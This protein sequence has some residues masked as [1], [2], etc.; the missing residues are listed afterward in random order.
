MEHRIKLTAQSYPGD[1]GDDWRQFQLTRPPAPR[2]TVPG[3]VDPNQEIIR[4]DNVAVPASLPI[5]LGGSP[6]L[7]I[8]SPTWA[9]PDGAV[10]ERVDG[11]QIAIPLAFQFMARCSPRGTLANT[12]TLELRVWDDTL[13]AAIGSSIVVDETVIDRYI[14][15]SVILP[16]REFDITWQ[17]RVLG[18]LRGAQAWGVRL[19]LDV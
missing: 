12:Q 7:L 15:R 18:G 11:R 2:P 19:K 17:A 4:P 9:I 5:H 8:T 1:A 16:L 14:L 10:I 13:G 6:A 3:T